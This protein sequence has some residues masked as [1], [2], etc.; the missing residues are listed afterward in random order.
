MQLAE[1]EGV[2][3]VFLR[4]NDLN[5]LKNAGSVSH[6]QAFQIAEARYESFDAGRREANRLADM[7]TDEM[8]ELKRIA[9]NLSKTSKDQR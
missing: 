8:N 9:D 3:D 5:V 7:K 1:W 4:S 2:L 6:E